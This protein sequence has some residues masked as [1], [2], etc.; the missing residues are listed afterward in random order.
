MKRTISILLFSL[1][2]G[3]LSAAPRVSHNYAYRHFTTRDGLPQMQLASAFQDSD[4]YIWFGTK[5]GVSRYDG[6]SFSNYTSAQGLP[7]GQPIEIFQ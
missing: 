2:I 6:V 7:Y 1:L 5:D 4:G 3:M